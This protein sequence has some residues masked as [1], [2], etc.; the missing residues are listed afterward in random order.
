MENCVKGFIN[1]CP[2]LTLKTPKKVA[3]IRLCGGAAVF[4]IYD[5]TDFVMPTEE[6]R[7][8]LKEMLCI[9]VVPFEET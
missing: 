5:D 6:Q 3:E 1:S 2:H 9:E 8:N 7:K 4:S